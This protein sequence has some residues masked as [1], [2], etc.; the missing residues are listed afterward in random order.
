MRNRLKFLRGQEIENDP[1][2][3][4]QF[5]YSKLDQTLKSYFSDVEIVPI[6]GKIAPLIPVSPLFPKRINRLFAQ[7]LLWCCRKD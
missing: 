1:T 2:H 4:R 3:V 7:D 5:S 6:R